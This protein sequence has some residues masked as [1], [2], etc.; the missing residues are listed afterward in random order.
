MVIFIFYRI[1]CFLL[2][3]FFSTIG[4]TYLIVY[5]S[6]FSLGFSFLGYL[7][8]VFSHFE[9]YFLIIGLFLLTLSLFFDSK[10]KKFISYLKDRRNP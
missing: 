4:V 7:K 2:G 10:W 1:L 9:I 3:I 6:L 5:L 8:Y